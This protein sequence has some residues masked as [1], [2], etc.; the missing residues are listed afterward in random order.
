M[1]RVTRCRAVSEYSKLQK[2]TVAD[3]E[4]RLQRERLEVQRLRLKLMAQNEERGVRSDASEL[5][6]IRRAMARLMESE[7][8]PNTAALAH[9]LR[10]QLDADES[11]RTSLRAS[12]PALRSCAPSLR[13]FGCGVSC[14]RCV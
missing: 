10:S 9:R 2:K 6:N 13:L 4:E 5:S 11:P 3:E 1:I 12:A 14:F 7:R 8:P